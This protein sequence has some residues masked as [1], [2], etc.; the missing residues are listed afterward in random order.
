MINFEN[1]L[2]NKTDSLKKLI[3]LNY[4]YAL[5]LGCGSGADSIAFSELG[6]SVVAVDQ[7]NST[8]NTYCPTSKGNYTPFKALWLRSW[9][10]I[11]FSLFHFC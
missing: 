4:K 7:S 5:D 8:P 1:S 6:L 9:F 2:K 3:Q 11:L 10:S